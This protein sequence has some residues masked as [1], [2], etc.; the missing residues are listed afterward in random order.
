M[1]NSKIEGEGDTLAY[2]E[3]IVNIE[4]ESERKKEGRNEGEIMRERN[5]V[6]ALIS[7][8]IKQFPKPTELA[9]FALANLV[10]KMHPHYK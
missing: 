8:H 3:H 2:V 10:R 9:R 5:I 1:F 7:V 4:E 6:L